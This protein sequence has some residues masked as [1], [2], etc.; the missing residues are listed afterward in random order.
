MGDFEEKRANIRQC[1]QADDRNDAD[2]AHDAFPKKQPKPGRLRA[3]EAEVYFRTPRSKLRSR[4][5]TVPGQER[6]ILADAQNDG[7]RTS[8]SD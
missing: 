4:L 3:W 1:D 6:I 7:T 2:A 8:A 5:K